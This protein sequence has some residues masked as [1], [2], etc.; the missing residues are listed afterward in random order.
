MNYLSPRYKIPSRRHFSDVELPELFN[1][2]SNHTRS[3]LADCKSA[4][5]FTTDIWTSN[6][7]LM[8]MLSLT[9]QW[10]DEDFQQHQVLLHCQEMPG[11]HSAA[12]LTTTFD[13][14]LQRWNI[15]KTRVHVVLL[16]NAR[17][18]SKALDD[19]NLASLPCMAHTLQLAVNEGLLSQRSI[20]DVVATGRKIIGHFKHSALAYSRLHD[21][22]EQLGQPKKRLQ[23]DVP[24]RWN[25]TYYMLQSLMEQR[26]ALGA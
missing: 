20:I 23:Q 11:S 3:L 14:M 15:D 6:V 13:T 8:S 25:S 17:N 18:M 21:I 26:R 5:S 4:F 12:N 19:G 7:S 16:D 22:Q 10:V 2:V 24:T 9:A 1:I